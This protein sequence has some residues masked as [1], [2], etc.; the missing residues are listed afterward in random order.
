MSNRRMVLEADRETVWDTIQRVDQF[1]R[2]WPWLSDFSGCGFGAGAVWRCTV[3]PPLPYKLRFTVTLEEVD[4]P[5]LVAA[6][7]S[8]DIS[9]TARI[10]L[11][12]RDGR[13]EACSRLMGCDRAAMCM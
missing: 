6:S 7:L 5:R 3:Q 11:H 9:G 13:C 8:G 1:S 12:D 2:W 10:E 4:G